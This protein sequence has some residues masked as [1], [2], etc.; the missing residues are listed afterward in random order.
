MTLQLLTVEQLEDK[1]SLS[2]ATIYRWLGAGQ[3]PRPIKVGNHATR[4]LSS[5]VDEWIACRA[6]SRDDA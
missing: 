1:L 5:E 3:F 2:K 4:W 6:E